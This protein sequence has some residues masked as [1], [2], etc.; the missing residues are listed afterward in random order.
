M[1]LSTEVYTTKVQES[2]QFYCTYFNFEV[3]LELEG[4]VVLQHTRKP[5][6]EL[7]F[8]VPDSPFVQEIFHPSFCGKGIIFQMEVED[9]EQEYKRVKA[10]NLPITLE[11]IEEPVNGRHF[12]VTDPNGIH[13]DIVQYT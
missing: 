2:K 1:R 8:C 5:E 7:L 12:T 13:V 9:V 3:K 11:L 6:Y 4:F 10:A